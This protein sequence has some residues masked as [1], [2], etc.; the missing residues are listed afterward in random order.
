MLMRQV[1]ELDI[2]VVPIANRLGQVHEY[3]ESDKQP[4]ACNDELQHYT[5]YF[6]NKK[7]DKAD[8]GLIT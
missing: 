5:G 1:T 2:L 7:K 8:F 3:N 6:R 4:D